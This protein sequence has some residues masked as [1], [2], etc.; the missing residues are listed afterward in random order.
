VIT[1]ETFREVYGVAVTV[2]EM[3][4]A[5]GRVARVSVPAVSATGRGMLRGQSG[6]PS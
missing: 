6:H 5:D 1:R 3:A 4:R 2:I